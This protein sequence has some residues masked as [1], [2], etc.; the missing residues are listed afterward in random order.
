MATVIIIDLHKV[1]TRGLA[2]LATVVPCMVTFLS[3]F[4][5]LFNGVLDLA[6][7]RDMTLQVQVYFYHHACA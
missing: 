6:T 4:N 7:A 2:A 3:F 5:T 1:L